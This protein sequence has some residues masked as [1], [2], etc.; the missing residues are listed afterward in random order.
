MNSDYFVDS[1]NDIALIFSS[2][3]LVWVQHHSHLSTHG[4]WWQVLGEAAS[5]TTGIAM[6]AH[7]LTPLNS[8]PGVI[9]GVLNF[10]NVANF[11][12]SIEF[13]S[14]SILAVLDMN[15]SLLHVLANSVSSESREDSLLV[16]PDWLRL[17]INLLLWLLIN[18]GR[19][20]WHF[21][22]EFSYIKK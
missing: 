1:L 21:L 22:L 2:D 16:K 13:G 7:N 9:D 4:T 20:F 14:S 12:S 8:E 10:L 6:W 3:G 19:S 15:E 17:V 5:N 18:W 11:L